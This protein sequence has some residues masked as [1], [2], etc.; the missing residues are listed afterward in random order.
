MKCRLGERKHRRCEVVAGTS[1]RSCWVRGNW[2]DGPKKWAECWS[3]P[4]NADMVEYGTGSAHY[5]YVRDGRLVPR[6]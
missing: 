5:P 1:Y 4:G 2:H 6:A 3:A